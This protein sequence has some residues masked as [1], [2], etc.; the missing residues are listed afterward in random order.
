MKYFVAY[1]F[2]GEGSRELSTVLGGVCEALRS[3]GH[4]VFCS[5]DKESWFKE[6]GRGAERI[7]EYCLDELIDADAILCFVRTSDKSSGIE[8]EV[9][10]SIQLGKPITLAVH[11][12]VPDVFLQEA[13]RITRASCAKVIEYTDIEAL[14]AALREL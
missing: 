6:Q 12:D 5:I 1:R 9:R 3:A 10:K 11:C 8:R 2:T 4:D 13:Y 7:Y 14:C